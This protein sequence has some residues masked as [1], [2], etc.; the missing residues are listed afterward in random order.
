MT[1]ATFAHL[2]LAAGGAVLSATGRLIYW[3]FSRFMRAPLANTGIL[4]LVSFGAMASSNALYLQEHEHP[5]PLFTPVQ[6]AAIA[7]MEPV[8]PP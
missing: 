5:N 2:P 8:I 4:C 6:Q 3:G 1:T 7:P